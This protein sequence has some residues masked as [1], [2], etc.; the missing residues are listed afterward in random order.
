MSK[1]CEMKMQDDVKAY[2]VDAKEIKEASSE[3]ESSTYME[4]MAFL[5]DI[6][7]LVD[8]SGII[9]NNKNNIL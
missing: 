9:N 6:F 3:K 7:A 1:I 2:I 4:V 8:F 5:R